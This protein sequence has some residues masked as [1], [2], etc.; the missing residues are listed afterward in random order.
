MAD[1]SGI[2]PQPGEGTSAPSAEAS[3]APA[4]SH[5]EIS[6][7]TLVHIPGQADPVKY[8]DLYKR[9]QGDHTKKTQALARDRTQFDSDRRTWDSSRTS[10][11]TELKQLATQLLA[12][13]NQGKQPAPGSGYLDQLGNK[14]YVS[15][16]E[17]AQLVRV[18]Q[19]QGFGNVSKAIQ[20]R[21]KV[22]NQLYGHFL[23][24]GKKVETLSNHR[25]SADFD[26][27]I[28]GWLNE[29]GV[30]PEAAELAKEVY[31]AYEGDDLEQEFPA[32]FK[33]RWDQLQSLYRAMDK[34]KVEEARKLSAFPGK[35]GGGVPGKAIEALKGNESAEQTADVLWEA[36]QATDSQTT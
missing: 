3:A 30:P 18:I 19:E 4:P 13:R 31:L 28:S 16:R 33:G 6:D 8:G 34:R 1:E 22:I 29:M 15:G 25:T 20:D 21:D 23:E 9:L 10:Q 12:M 32:I 24:L 11:E 35:G 7:S 17:M 36:L 14:S 27:K 2:T 5:A 26:H